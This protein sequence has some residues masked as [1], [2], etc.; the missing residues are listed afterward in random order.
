MI[1]AVGR[2]L[3][4]VQ[5]KFKFF[6]DL[7]SYLWVEFIGVFGLLTNIYDETICEKNT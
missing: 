3:W 4:D 1:F 2:N 5:V 7:Y 6:G